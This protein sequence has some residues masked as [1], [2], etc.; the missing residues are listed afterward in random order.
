MQSL[1][2]NL[3]GKS[4]PTIKEITDNFMEIFKRFQDTKPTNKDNTLRSKDYSQAANVNINSS[5]KMCVFCKPY[6]VEGKNIPFHHASKCTKY[7]DA[8]SKLDRAR[9]LS[10]CLKCLGK[11]HFSKNC[12]VKLGK[13]VHCSQFHLSFIC[14]KNKS[15]NKIYREKREKETSSA[16]GICQSQNSNV[17]HINSGKHLI[18]PTLD[19]KICSKKS[20]LFRAYAMCDSGS[21][22]SFITADVLPHINYK[23]VNYDVNATIAGINESK[24]YLTKEILFQALIDGDLKY[25]KATVLPNLNIKMY[26]PGLGKI[27][28]HFLDKG[29]NLATARISDYIDRVKIVLG[30]NAFDNFTFKSERFGG[31]GE[32]EPSSYFNTNVGVMLFGNTIKLNENIKYLPKNNSC[33][34]FDPV[35]NLDWEKSG[36]K[37]KINEVQNIMQNNKKNS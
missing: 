14:L 27:Q 15:N 28:R 37:E 34:T 13:C 2:V 3:L 16:T 24:T 4:Y 11:G 35:E 10:L 6:V 7:S 32:F 5:D 9:Q 21:Q 19:L 25:I 17:Y 1:Y 23:V 30:V 36:E 8:S 26:I 33:T 22:I 29:Y 31:A 18:V 20:E 12:T